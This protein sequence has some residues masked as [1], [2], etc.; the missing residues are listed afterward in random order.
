MTDTVFTAINKHHES[1]GTPP[2]ISNNEDRD[3]YYGYFEGQNGDQWVFVYD[4]VTG[5]GRLYGGDVEWDNPGVV[6]GDTAPFILDEAESSW[7]AACLRA[8]KLQLPL[9]KKG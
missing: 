1:C 9:R 5:Q 7:Y 2:G 6:S 8:V 3:H 4:F